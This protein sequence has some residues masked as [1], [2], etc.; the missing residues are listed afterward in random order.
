[1]NKKELNFQYSYVVPTFIISF[2][3]YQDSLKI[4]DNE[5]IRQEMAVHHNWKLSLWAEL[6]IKSIMDR[7]A[8]DF[9]LKLEGILVK[10]LDII[11]KKN[12]MVKGTK[13]Y[14]IK[15]GMMLV[16]KYCQQLEEIDFDIERLNSFVTEIAAAGELLN[17]KIREG[18]E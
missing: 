10:W 7:S 12:F 3:A 15:L 13:S 5:K 18:F 17:R 9:N 4:I 14:M 6:R 16:N 11:F 2:N 1:M 8:K